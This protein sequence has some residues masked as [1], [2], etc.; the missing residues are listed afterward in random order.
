MR[1]ESND[2]RPSLRE[3]LLTFLGTIALASGLFWAGKVIPIIRQ[4][5]H[6]CIAVI[7][8]YAPVVA[9]RLTGRRFDF[10]EA[11]LRLDPV[12]TNALVLG[13][14]VGVTFPLFVASFFGFYDVVC[15]VRLARS[16][17]SVSSHFLGDMVAGMCPGSGW[18]PGSSGI[19]ARLAQLRLP[20]SFALLAANQ[21]LVIALPEEMFFRGY[22]LGRLEWRWPPERRF[23]GAPVGRALLVSAA[24]FAL[25]HF[26]VDFNPQRLAVFFPAL[27]FGWMRARTGSIAPGTAF[28]A[29]CNLLAD[30]L[31][32]SYF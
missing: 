23:L 9:G 12:R 28:H 24:L 32:T 16:M 7:F 3:P 15:G 27:V 10:Q 22:L 18:Q 29:L 8:L 30:V 6:A 13:L 26:L 2:V 1:V 11:G 4:N 5:L 21:V 17:A 31:H 14:A 19:A 25:G 20:P